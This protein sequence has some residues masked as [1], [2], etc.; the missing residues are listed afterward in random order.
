VRLQRMRDT[1]GFIVRHYAGDVVYHTAALVSQQTKHA[2]VDWL[3]KNNDTLQEDWLGQL[4]KSDV[5]L[6]ASLFSPGY[7]ASLKAKKTAA[8]S[9]VGKRFVNDLNGLLTELKSS[10]A[11]FI[12]CIKPNM[13]Q[14]PKLFTALMVLDQLRCSGVVEAVR[15][16]QEAYPTR[17]PYEDIYGRY[18]PLMGEEIMAETGDDAAAFCEAV[19]LACEV[20]SRDYALG[21]TKLFLKAGCG[22]FLEDLASMD[23]AVVV[24]LLI[25][26]IAAS[27]RK[28]AAAMLVGQKVLAWHYRK[29]E[30]AMAENAARN[31]EKQALDAMRPGFVEDGADPDA[32]LAEYKSRV[33]QS[34]ARASGGGAC[35]RGLAGR[36]GAPLAWS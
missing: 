1:E 25:E 31:I 28:A 5:P 13:E 12:R 36:G 30:E 21:L 7:E 2:E 26:K 34:D 17:I 19:A 14:K 9:S 10:K 8:F 23:P 24:P 16:M 11:H 27:K 32:A 15:V 29:A 3:N 35:P 4:A 20:S 6:L 22:S 18:A 33:S